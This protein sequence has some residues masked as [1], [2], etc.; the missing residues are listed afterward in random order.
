MLLKG[1]I[2]V[3]E[4]FMDKIREYLLG[5]PRRRK[6]LLQVATD[7]VLVWA[8]LWLA[9]IVRLGL[10]DM[11]NPFKVHFWLFVCAPIVA[12]PLFIRFGMYGAVTRYF[13]NVALCAF[14]KAVRHS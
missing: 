12:I 11:Y 10:D 1:V 7:I 13:V 14:F 9:F 3:I 8:A 5:L 2:K 4:G 6:R